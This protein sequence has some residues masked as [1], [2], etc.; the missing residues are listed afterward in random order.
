MTALDR[1]YRRARATLSRP[2]P[3]VAAA[4]D[5]GRRR[6]L[7]ARREVKA[8]LEAGG[9]ARALYEAETDKAR[10]VAL[11]GFLRRGASALEG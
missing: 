11:L 8:M 3:S 1:P 2:A 10:R 7:E 9:D 6:D 4:I 5:A